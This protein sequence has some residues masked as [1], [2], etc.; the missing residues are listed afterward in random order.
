MER[1]HFQDPDTD[2]LM[3]EIFNTP[4]RLS[5]RE[6]KTA[7][8]LDRLTPLALEQAHLILHVFFVNEDTPLAEKIKMVAEVLLAGPDL[9]NDYPETDVLSAKIDEVKVVFD[10]FTAAVGTRH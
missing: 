1:Y 2:G 7:A 3:A 9:Q 5:S 6:Y 10:Q 8:A 4:E